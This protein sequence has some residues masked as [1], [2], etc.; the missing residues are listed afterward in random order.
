MGGMQILEPL[1]R[2][3]WNLI[4]AV[5]AGFAGFIIARVALWWHERRDLDAVLDAQRKV[6]KLH[7]TT[8][9]EEFHIDFVD[10]DEVRE[11][12]KTLTK[13]TRTDE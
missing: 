9:E 11:I 13:R 1:S 10:L 4:M 2:F 8:F 7:I 12:L 6:E 3:P 5:L